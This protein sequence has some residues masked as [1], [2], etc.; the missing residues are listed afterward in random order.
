MHQLGNFALIS[1]SPYE[2][3][4]FFIPQLNHNITRPNITLVG[5]DMK[6]TLHTRENLLIL[7]PLSQGHAKIFNMAKQISFQNHLPK[8][9]MYVTEGAKSHMG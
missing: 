7:V 9:N 1:T 6:M 3:G 4:I 8:P 5:L 2:N